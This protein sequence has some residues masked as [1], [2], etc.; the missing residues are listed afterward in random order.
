[1]SDLTWA[2]WRADCKARGKRPERSDPALRAKRLKAMRAPKPSAASALRAR[3]VPSDAEL[4][5]RIAE[6][7]AFVAASAARTKAQGKWRVPCLGASQ[8]RTLAALKA[9]ALTP[10][11]IARAVGHTQYGALVT[12]LGGLVHLGLIESQGDAWRA[13]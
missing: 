12:T 8:Q 11:E 9:K 13:R 6:R 4:N 7:A 1:M 2:E 3:G 10:T 5:R